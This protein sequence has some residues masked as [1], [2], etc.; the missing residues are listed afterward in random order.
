MRCLFR[1]HVECIYDDDDGQITDAVQIVVQFVDTMQVFP[2]DKW[3][4]C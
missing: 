2:T 1:P 4:P 3:S